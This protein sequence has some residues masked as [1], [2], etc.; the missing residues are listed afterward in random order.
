MV[1]SWGIQNN[2]AISMNAQ[3]GATKR[4]KATNPAGGTYPNGIA[5][6]DM[7]GQ[8]GSKSIT[9]ANSTAYSS[10]FILS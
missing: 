8:T 5:I 6:F 4:G 9:A 10:S 3:T 2:T 1:G 7:T